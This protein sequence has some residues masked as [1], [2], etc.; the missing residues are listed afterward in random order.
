M[1]S[2]AADLC[3]ALLA[4]DDPA[5]V[6]DTLIRYGEAAPILITPGDVAEMREAARRLLAVFAA[7][8][9]DEAARLLNDLL[10][11]CA[12]PP[13]LTD[14]GGTTGW[15][16]HVDTEDAGW[17]QW[18]LSSSAM[19]LALL[20]SEQQ[21]LPGGLCASAACRLPYVD[22]GGGSA[23]RYCSSRCA[24]RERVAAHRAASRS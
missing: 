17:G 24:T 21:R 1:A 16:V 8:R 2:R 7:S 14:H 18:F 9:L 23:R 11:G 19:A 3:R 22:L 12:R 5:R 20:L 4:D 15:H 10:A 6:E 13:R